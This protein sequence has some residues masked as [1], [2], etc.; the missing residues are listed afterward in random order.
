MHT[1]G[2]MQN[3]V[4]IEQANLSGL[5]PASIWGG[6]YAP[7]TQYNDGKNSGPWMM[8]TATLTS[9]PTRNGDY[10]TQAQQNYLS[11]GN[12]EPGM[13]NTTAVVSVPAW[14]GG[15]TTQAQQNHS[16]DNFVLGVMNTATVTPPSIL[17]YDPLHNHVSASV[18]AIVT[19]LFDCTQPGC[20]ASFRR[21]SDR[22]RHEA[23]KHGIN[24]S[25]HFCQIPGCPKSQGVGYK[26]RTN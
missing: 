25:L 23:S 20:Q 17:G 19:D 9:V 12:F 1:L 14:D 3:T 10:A 8:N 7:D 16:N 24:G 6:D 4:L 22:I 13:I 5:L 15:Y 18:P 26:A 11:N 2:P 21:D